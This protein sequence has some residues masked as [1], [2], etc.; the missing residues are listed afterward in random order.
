[1][2][3]KISITCPERKT[4]EK[5]YELIRNSTIY[6]S[7]VIVNLEPIKEVCDECSIK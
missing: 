3:Y 5:I 2:R 7:M 1:M 4:A 6:N